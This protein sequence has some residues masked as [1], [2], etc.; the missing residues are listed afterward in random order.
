[1]AT[2]IHAPAITRRPELAG[3]GRAASPSAV[4]PFDG[5][6]ANHSKTVITSRSIAKRNTTLVIHPPIRS[7]PMKSQIPACT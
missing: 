4:R 7:A 3:C 5:P 1:M 6:G 2:A